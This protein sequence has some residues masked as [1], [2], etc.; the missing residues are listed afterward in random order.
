MASR[1][2]RKRESQGITAVNARQSQADYETALGQ[3]KEA[4]KEADAA[5]ILTGV[6]S[7]MM[8]I[9]DARFR[10]SVEARKKVL[11]MIAQNAE[12]QKH[13]QSV[14]DEGRKSGFKESG[15]EIIKCCMAGACMMLHEEFGFG[16]DDIIRGLKTLY[17][18]TAYALNY[19]EIA[20]DV[21]KK[22][23]IELR[24]E[25][26]LEPIRDIR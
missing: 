1:A 7:G 21:L 26:P 17:D 23:G 20:E 22:T 5:P 3:L 18:K 10:N 12:L 13:I 19:S 16:D 4:K 9:N 15:W 8:Q 25:D 11:D 6:L 24:L 14:F 2:K